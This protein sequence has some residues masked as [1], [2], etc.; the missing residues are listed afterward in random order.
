[1]AGER[2][3]MTAGAVDIR[4]TAVL[5]YAMTVREKKDEVRMNGCSDTRVEHDE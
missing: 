3:V 5:L 4:Y 2:D 1:M